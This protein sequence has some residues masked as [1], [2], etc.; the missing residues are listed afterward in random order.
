[1]DIKSILP[2]LLSGNK[3]A[4]QIFPFLNAMNL[5]GSSGEQNDIVK[6]PNETLKAELLSKAMSKTQPKSRISGF[7]PIL[8]IVNDDILGKMIKYLSANK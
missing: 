3:N 4:E 6:N 5:G 8:G 7:T 1:M 2:L